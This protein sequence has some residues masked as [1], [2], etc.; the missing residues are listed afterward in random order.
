MVSYFP[1]QLEIAVANI[2]EIISLI[3]Y[4]YNPANNKLD[5]LNATYNFTDNNNEKFVMYFANLVET[6]LRIETLCQAINNI[7]MFSAI[8]PMCKSVESAMAKFGNKTIDYFNNLEI[9][10]AEFQ[11]ESFPNIDENDT[12]NLNKIHVDYV[13]FMKNLN[14]INLHSVITQCANI[15]LENITQEMNK[16]MKSY[17][18]DFHYCDEKYSSLLVEFFK[19]VETVTACE[20][21][22][23]HRSVKKT[24]TG[25]Y[26]CNTVISSKRGNFLIFQ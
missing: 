11:N 22:K 12:H 15:E 18:V 6:N 24:G 5:H 3:T 13:L 8:E 25:T 21:I 26:V 17:K 1:D 20:V 2:T 16:N 19:T 23:K 9:F 7:N 10:T 14:V 4:F